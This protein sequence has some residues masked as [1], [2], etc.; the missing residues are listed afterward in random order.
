MARPKKGIRQHVH[1]DPYVYPGDGG[2]VDKALEWFNAQP[3][4]QR[5]RMC[6]ELIVAAVNGE[7]GVAS[8]VSVM[9]NEDEQIAQAALENLLKNMVMDE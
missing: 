4:G 6:W 8:T 1:I 2:R 3:A 5:T 9:T 7:L